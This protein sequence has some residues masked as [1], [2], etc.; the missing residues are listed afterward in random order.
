MLGQL[1]EWI[2]VRR[3]NGAD[4]LPLSSETSTKGQDETQQREV[5]TVKPIAKKKKTAGSIYLINLLLLMHSLTYAAAGSLGIFS[6]ISR[7]VFAVSVLRRCGLHSLGQCR[8]PVV[9]GEFL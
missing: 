2:L 8:E 3:E 6:L 9:R 4:L 7:W 5:D 1:I